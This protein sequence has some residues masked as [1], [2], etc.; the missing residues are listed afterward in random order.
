MTWSA[1]VVKLADCSSPMPLA[2]HFTPLCYV[3][4]C[5][6]ASE[7]EVA[8]LIRPKGKKWPSFEHCLRQAQTHLNGATVRSTQCLINNKNKHK[9]ASSPPFAAGVSRLCASA[10]SLSA[11]VSVSAVS[12]PVSLLL[13][14]HLV[15]QT[16]KQGPK[17]L[18]QGIASIHLS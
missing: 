6:M 8:G 10:V 16:R 5:W 15:T 12:G 2:D 13:S 14:G 3:N 18:R 7:A 17:Q 4:G 11:P 1:R 9:I